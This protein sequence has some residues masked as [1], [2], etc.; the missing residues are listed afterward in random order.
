MVFTAC[1]WRVWWSALQAG[2]ATL[3][4]IVLQVILKQT[5]KNIIPWV[6]RLQQ[7][8]QVRIEDSTHMSICPS[9]RAQPIR[10]AAVPSAW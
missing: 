9:H 3:S 10:K 2:R 1:K 7:K 8:C 6:S 4:A 5:Y